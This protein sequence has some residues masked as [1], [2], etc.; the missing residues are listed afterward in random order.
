[1]LLC[2]AAGTARAE[3]LDVSTSFELA[4][5]QQQPAKTTTTQPSL[6]AESVYTYN[7]LEG[8]TPMRSADTQEP[9]TLDLKLFSRWFT[10]S[11]HTDDDVL[12]E[13]SMQWGMAEN[14]EMFATLP[15]NFGDGSQYGYNGNPDL[16]VGWQWKF[17]E[18]Q[19]W[20]PGTAVF[21][22]VRA[23]TGYHSSGSDQ[24]VGLALTKSLIPDQ[25]RLHFNTFAKWLD[26]ANDPPT[27]S[28][29]VFAP[30]PHTQRNFEFGFILGTDYA[31][32]ESMGVTLEYICDSGEQNGFGMQH[33]AWAG[34]GIKL[35]NGHEVLMSVTATLDGD[36]QGP[37]AGATIGYLIPLA[38]VPR[39]T[40][41]STE[42]CYPTWTTGE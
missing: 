21:F 30:A 10:A 17:L 25:W 7:D 3:T 37:N 20:I 16:T 19:E 35:D 13:P 24:T 22:A 23:P 5:A 36:S 8:V 11:D 18:E 42:C 9:G 39:M 15:I 12:L 40:W 41:A 14:L 29:D 38:P 27:P 1:M 31:I 33:S 26:G 2:A 4:A 34:M 6:T 32:N 28:D